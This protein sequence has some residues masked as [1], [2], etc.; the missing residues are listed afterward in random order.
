[1]MVSKL[2]QSVY[3][4]FGRRSIRPPKKCCSVRLRFSEFSL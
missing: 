3:R 1:M 2:Q 4:G